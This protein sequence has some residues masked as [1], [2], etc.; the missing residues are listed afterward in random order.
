MAGESKNN[1]L[2]SR[3]LKTENIL[4]ANLL[5]IQPESFKEISSEEKAHLKASLAENGFADPFNVWEDQEGNIW[6]LDGKHRASLLIELMADGIKVPVR[7]PANFFKC[8]DKQ[9]AAKLVLIYSSRYARITPHG[10]IEFTEAYNINLE[11]IGDQIIL[12]E[13]A[14]LVPEKLEY[15]TELIGGAKD[16]PATIK[17]TFKT[18]EDLERAKP[19]VEQLLN[20]N[21]AGSFFSVSC[22]EI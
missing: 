5:F 19:A 8:S 12:P 1:I 21:F 4:W 16:K 18:H 17:I 7:L 10:L 20:E 13:V 14:D 15:P 9:E 11:E 6:C 22:G 3:L 2:R